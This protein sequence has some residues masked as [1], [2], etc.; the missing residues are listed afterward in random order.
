MFK[1]WFGDR[2]FYSKAL[3]VAI[4]IMIQTGI[5]NFVNMLDNVMVGQLG[6]DAISG[7]AIINQLMFVFN[8]CI[9]GAFSGVGIFTAQFYGKGDHEGVRYTFRMQV[10]AA[11]FL[12]A[13]G[14]FVIL[15]WG[16]P[17]I[18]RFL[19]ADSGG[20]TVDGTLTLAKK[21]LA[22]M[23]IEIIP[24]AFVQVYSNTLRNTG[25]T[26]VP[27]YAG[28]IAVAVNLV[29]NYIL[30][31]GKFGAPALG[32]TGA[33]IAT[34]LSRFVEFFIVAGWTHLNT[35]KNPF[36][37]GAYRHLFRMP[38]S[39]VLRVMGKAWPLLLNEGLWSA[40]QTVLVR[41]YS[42]RGLSAVTAMN[43]SN[44]IANVFNIAFIAMGSA[45]AILLGQ[46]L[47]RGEIER[48]KADAKKLTVFSVL[49]CIGM[50][51][52]LICVS[53]FFP[54]VYNTT[55]EIRNIA[56]GLIRIAAI[57]MPVYA[58]ENAAYFTIRSGGK[59]FIT[60]V[61]DSV[62][63]WCVSIPAAYLFTTYTDFPIMKLCLFVNL[64]EF[65]KCALGYAL[66][67]SGSWAK[68]LTIEPVK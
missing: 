41:I 35:E 51:L 36:I 58:Y 49:L 47:G 4:P 18:M 44:T 14:F 52:L 10:F 50:G 46:M 5:T 6:T 8:L 40:G 9:F 13:L 62:F 2:K 65:T 37:V 45:T 38:G 32:V 29:G 64:F 23:M 57:F 42:T 7:V 67:R 11:L 25:E 1:D 68:N 56:S 34:V 55:D 53:P 60:F 39:L 54:K 48:A 12:I 21:Y 33:A 19:T 15:T 43:I 26:V 59:T 16:D 31:Y 66:K 3:A 17:I 22:V 61:F 63:V 27:M 28:L 24:F 20:G 30:I